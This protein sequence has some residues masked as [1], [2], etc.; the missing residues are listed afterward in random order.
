MTGEEA[1]Q[2]AMSMKSLKCLT[3][4]AGLNPPSSGKMSE[5]FNQRRT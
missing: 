1:G 3:K 2:T 5:D 4:D